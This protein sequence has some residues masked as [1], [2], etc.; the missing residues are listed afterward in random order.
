MSAGFEAEKAKRKLA[1]AEEAAQIV[2]DAEK[3]YQKVAKENPE[4]FEDKNLE[5]DTDTPDDTAL[6]SDHT[7]YNTRPTTALSEEAMQAVNAKDTMGLI[8]AITKSSNPLHRKVSSAL[9]KMME[10][11]ER[12]TRLKVQ[13]L[14][15]AEG[16]FDPNK[17]LIVL[18]KG[19]LTEETA[20]HEMV[21]AV[22]YSTLTRDPSTLTPA[23]RDARTDIENLFNKVK[24]NPDFKN[25][26]GNVSVED[27]VSEVLTNSNLRDKLDALDKTLWQRFIQAIMKMIG[28]DSNTLSNKTADAAMR[29]FE[30]PQKAT[31]NNAVL[32]PSA[33]RGVFA[34]RSAI[35]SES[36]DPDIARTVNN[37][38]GKVGGIGDRIAATALGLRARVAIAD[39]WASTDELVSLGVEKGKVSEAQAL[40]MRL[41]MRVSEDTN[42]LTSQALTNGVP[43]LKAYEGGVKILESVP[44]AN[45]IDIA[46]ALKESKLGNASFVE[47]LFTNWLGI[48]RTEKEGL[49]LATLNFG[50]DAEGR[51]VLDTYKAA[52][53]KKIVNDDPATRAAFEKARGI[54]KKY[55][56]N[57]MNM[58]VK[59]SY[60]SRE[61]ASE[62][63]VGDFVPFYRVDKGLVQLNVGRNKITIGSVVDQPHLKELVG[64]SEKILPI[65]SGMVQNTSFLIH[66]AVR[67][68]Q[69]G[70]VA[71]IL[72]DMDL[73][74]VVKG[75]GP[76]DVYTARFKYRGEDYHA[77]LDN[78]AFP[79]NIPAD[80]VI[81]G[82][83]GIKTAIPTMVKAMALPVRLLRKGITRIPT[84]A[85]RQLQRDSIH[86]WMTTGG[87]FSM[88]LDTYKEFAKSL[89]GTTETEAKLSRAGAISSMLQTGDSEDFARILRDITSGGS[90]MSWNKAMSKLDA[91]GMKADA[92]T[93]S[94]VYNEYRKRGFSHLESILASAES[95]NF[96]RRGTSSSLHWISSMVPFFNSAIQ[97]MD[98]LYRAAR[99]KAAF[100]DR[101]DIQRKLL[102]RGALMAAMTAAYSMVMQDDDTY[103]NATTSERARSWFVPVPGGGTLALPI[104]FE[105]GLIF[106]TIP[107]MIVN[108]LAGDTKARDAYQALK[109][110]LLT[111][112][113]LDLPTLI[114]PA[115]ELLANH[116]FFTD[117]PIE[118]LREERLPPSMR[119]RSETTEL[120][121]L[122]GKAEV[123]SP[124]Q[125]EHLVKGYTGSIGMLVMN[126]ANVVLRP[127][128]AQ[129]GVDRPTREITQMP[130]IKSMFQPEDGRGM[131]ES[132]FRDIESFE[133]A[134][135]KYKDLIA[136]GNR[137]EAAAFANKYATEITLNQTGG[138]FKQKMGEL[139]QLRRTITA[140]PG[141]SGDQKREQLKAIRQ[142][143]I[144]LAKQIRSISDAK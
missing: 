4:L 46:E 76:R 121:K 7:A 93:R 44:G 110:Q 116:S 88:V 100:Q 141:I 84:Y 104:P 101:M 103:K 83:Q 18:D 129:E 50:T 98:S 108:L 38:V 127:F 115:T 15:D 55:N 96:A 21:H 68:M 137:A 5:S 17:N 143:E 24:A 2:T 126:A 135:V 118:S 122:L 90:G 20:L 64:G 73:A 12:R 1:K 11:L 29:L 133:R 128:T 31:T 62:L 6:R 140:A 78:D 113:P 41:L 37:V 97:G 75:P 22:T 111:S 13:D 86:A 33:M 117:S 89:K 72:Q 131:I 69:T 138:A 134:A 43:Q 139:A 70:N 107:E 92:A 65:F 35:A 52:A 144:Q 45:A 130:F 95:M 58:L 39:K 82:L 80:V 99:G 106:K 28:L 125:I 25:E 120:A 19:S 81:M 26:Y 56:E 49:S 132:A 91:L 109:A 87:N 114:K 10:S 67:N 23:Q 66:A 32:L 27:F 71:N 136:T 61:K 94:A 54:Y 60:I 3:N 102:K 77:I 42:R 57:L 8:S 9:E 36:V 79:E 16:Y 112:V 59:A 34:G 14:P 124:L 85:L 119:V 63:L 48:L 30:P 40:Q 142:I 105:A 51:P 123:L 74:K 53:I 47:N